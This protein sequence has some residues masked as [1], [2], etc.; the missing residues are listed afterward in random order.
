MVNEWM[1]KKRFPS[2]FGATGVINHGSSALLEEGA[3]MILFGAFL[4]A[5]AGLLFGLILSHLVRFF[6]YVSGRHVATTTWMIVSIVVGA[7]VCGWVASLD[8]GN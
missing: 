2:L 5:F 8:D 7:V 6:A 1:S 4:G 3:T